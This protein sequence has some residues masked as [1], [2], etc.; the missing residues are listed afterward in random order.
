[1][2]K[3]KITTKK[4]AQTEVSP[5]VNG[6]ATEQTNEQ[7]VEQ[8]EKTAEVKTPAKK[9]ERKMY[10]YRAWKN[11]AVGQGLTAL[12]AKC[13]EAEQAAM[14][15][16]KQFGTEKFYE[17]PIALVGGVAALV[18][19]NADEVDT[20]VW[21]VIE[22]MENTYTL[23]LPEGFDYTQYKDKDLTDEPKAVQL[24]MQRVALPLVGE[25]MFLDVVMPKVVLSPRTG[26][27]LPIV[28]NKTPL[29]FKGEDGFWYIGV[30]FELA[31]D[32]TPVLYNTFQ[33]MIKKSTANE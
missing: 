20:E 7:T 16:V 26:K 3:K 4:K 9:T 10:Y 21:K 31:A 25:A 13:Q 24:E 11:G 27:P 15:W 30:P 14:E 5:K 8:T 18:F 29:W 33:A 28:M 6:T 32:V 22:G 1:M 2:A 23:N 17:D 12:F 19:D